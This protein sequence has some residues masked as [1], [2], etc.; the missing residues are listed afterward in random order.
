[1]RRDFM[2]SRRH[3]RA[4]TMP[5][6]PRIPGMRPGTHGGLPSLSAQCARKSGQQLASW[7]ATWAKP[8]RVRSTSQRHGPEPGSRRMRGVR[9]MQNSQQKAHAPAFLAASGAHRRCA[10]ARTQRSSGAAPPA[11]PPRLRVPESYRGVRDDWVGAP[12]AQN[13]PAPSL[14]V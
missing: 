7:N 12:R 2:H 9:G 10:C 8:S 14:T 5:A 13:G 6:A 1:M 11:S 4:A 3:A